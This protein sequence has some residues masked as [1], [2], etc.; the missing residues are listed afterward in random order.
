MYIFIYIVFSFLGNYNYFTLMILY[1]IMDAI[2]L[3]FI[4]TQN[5]LIAAPVQ[6]GMWDENTCFVWNVLPVV[7][8]LVFW[9]CSGQLLKGTRSAGSSG[10]PRV[11]SGLPQPGDQMTLVWP[12]F[13][14][15]QICNFLDSFKWSM[16]HLDIYYLT[17]LICNGKCF[18]ILGL[19]AKPLPKPMLTYCQLDP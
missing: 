19:G 9:S 5:A 11:R 12:S 4:Q 18:Q 1:I 3:V 8:I 10:R 16:A 14:S 2:C 13:S 7:F 15:T 17:D 6:W